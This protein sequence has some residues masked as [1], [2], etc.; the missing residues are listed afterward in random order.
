M[1]LLSTNPHREFILDAFM[2]GVAVGMLAS[3]TILTV[4]HVYTKPTQEQH[5]QK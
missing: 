5:G 3:F 2:I 4:Y 1:T